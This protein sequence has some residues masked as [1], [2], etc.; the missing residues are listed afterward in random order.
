MSIVTNYYDGGKLMKMV[1]IFLVFVVLLK[2]AVGLAGQWSDEYCEVDLRLA[3]FSNINGHKQVDKIW[4]VETKI[5]PYLDKEDCLQQALK[6][7]EK[8]PEYIYR[9]HLDQ[10]LDFFSPEERQSVAEEIDSYKR[11]FRKPLAFFFEWK[12]R[13]NYHFLHISNMFRFGQINKHTDQYAS[14]ALAGGR[15]CF[16]ADGSLWPSRHHREI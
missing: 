12:K 3:T 10:D 8:Y 16:F 2:N 9:K 15:Y 1:G 5:Y 13:T 4:V 11:N 14:Q 7:A 6:Y